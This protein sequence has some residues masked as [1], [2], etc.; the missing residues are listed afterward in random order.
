MVTIPLNVVVS[1]NADIGP[2]TIPLSINSSF[3]TEVYHGPGSSNIGFKVPS[4]E[5]NIVNQTSDLT[6]EVQKR[7]DAG[8]KIATF[9]KDF[10]GPISLIGGGFVGGFS[11]WILGKVQRKG[12]KKNES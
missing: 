2:Q 12:S 7:L 5:A 10:G 3:P 9:W 8:Q 11:G 1:R 6:V 4:T